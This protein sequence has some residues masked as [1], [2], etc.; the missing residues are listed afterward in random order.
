MATTDTSN[1]LAGEVPAATLSTLGF[2][3]DSN[4]KFDVL[5][6]HIFATD[7]NQTLLFKQQLASLPY[8]I[9]R[10]GSRRGD[11]E[12]SLRQGFYDYLNKYYQD[13]GVQVEI[14]DFEGSSSLVN[15][16]LIITLTENFKQTQYGYAVRTVRKKLEQLIKLNNYGE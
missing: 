14:T 3:R 12:N 13:V 16:K 1:L 15:F 8:W 10:G 2:V 5:M 11:I 6:A 9:E 4:N 7:Y